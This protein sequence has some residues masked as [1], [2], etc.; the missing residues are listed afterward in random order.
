MPGAGPSRQS[1]NP[2]EDRITPETVDEL[3]E[4]WTAQT[5]DGAVGDPVTSVR[6]VHVNDRTSVY[7][8]RTTTGDRLWSHQPAGIEAMEQPYVSGEEV[9][10]SAVRGTGAGP[11]TVVDAATG[12]PVQTLAD[13]RALGALSGDHALV[14]KIT[15]TSI[16]DVFDRQ[17]LEWICCD[18]LLFGTGSRPRW[19]MTLGAEAFFD[20][21]FGPTH[22]DIDDLG[23]GIRM[24][25]IDPPQPCWWIPIGMCPAWTTPLDGSDSALPVLSDDEDTVYVGTDAGT[26]HAVE[27]A[28][29]DI[30]W[31][32]AT[33]SAITDSPALA[34]GSLYVPTEADGLVV[35]DA[36]GCGT[37]VCEPL[38]TGSAT[39]AITQQPAAAGGVVFAGTA[40]GAVIAFD[41]AGCGTPVCEPSW[42]DST[43]SEITGAPAVHNGQ[44]YVGTADGRLVA[45]GLA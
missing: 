14:W 8:F 13:D 30:L 43:G 36:D 38:W 41:G 1:H 27:A 10:T 2:V 32:A 19:E 12:T 16:V 34:D 17:T 45:Y 33:G 22:V 9:W 6:G 18:D 44:L 29:G 3:D 42:V 26:I 20:A 15:T 11:T 35:L 31:K 24:Y 28:T 7:G 5:D 25:Q 40:D 37:P 39:A 21:G 4:V 23:N